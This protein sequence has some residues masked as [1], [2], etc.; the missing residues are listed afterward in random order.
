MLRLEV[1]V[2]GP[3]KSKNLPCVARLPVAAALQ[4]RRFAFRAD[5]DGPVTLT[6]RPVTPA[7]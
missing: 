6:L 4:R 5:H 7:C 3:K 1:A 2:A